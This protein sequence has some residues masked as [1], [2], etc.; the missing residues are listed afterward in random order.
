[1]ATRKRGVFMKDTMLKI[2]VSASQM[3]ALRSGAKSEGL[4]V[5]AFVLGILFP[6]E[7]KVLPGDGVDEVL[8]TAAVVGEA[9]KVNP[10]FK[11]SPKCESGKCQRL[12]RPTCTPCIQANAKGFAS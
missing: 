5:S 6:N 10:D 9:P 12:Q 3:E 4:S 1:M 8:A 2:R 11:R 7:G